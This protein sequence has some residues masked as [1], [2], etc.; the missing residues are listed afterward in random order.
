MEYAVKRPAKKFQT[1]RDLRVWQ[2][3][4]KL[5]VGIYKIAEKFPKHEL[6][7]L[8]SQM[9]RA[10]VS[11][12]SNIAEGYGRKSGQDKSHFYVMANGSLTEL[13]N[14]LLIAQGIGYIDKSL[15]MRIMEQCDTVHKMLYGLQRA[16][17]N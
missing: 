5:A 4:Y 12:S 7:G 1:F 14:Q 9:T 13:E 2:E 11:V 6:Y 3:S 10:A 16:N 17:N 15:L 8:S